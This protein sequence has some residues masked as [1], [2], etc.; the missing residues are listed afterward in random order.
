MSTREAFI[1]EVWEGSGKE[2]IGADE[3]TAIQ[4]A[5]VEKFG[6]A[7][8]P[9]PALIARVLADEGAR[10]AHPQIL[11]ADSRWREQHFFF[12]S[13]NLVFDTL[14]SAL[15]FIDKVQQS[16]A[17]QERLR[18]SVQQVKTELDALAASQ[19]V[20]LKHRELAREV[21]QWLT[22]WLQNPQIFAEWLA[23]RQS[24]AEFQELFGTFTQP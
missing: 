6:S 18:L 3:L 4:D 1:V 11:Q 2:V 9:S 23:L 7:A 12:T 14:N 21:S 13:D 10:L 17:T 22:I 15:A 16:D 24:T 19:T 5:V 20:T 8:T